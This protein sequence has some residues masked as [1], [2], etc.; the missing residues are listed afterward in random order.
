MFFKMDPQNNSKNFQKHIE[1]NIL[2]EFQLVK[3]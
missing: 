3:K 1:V 2:K